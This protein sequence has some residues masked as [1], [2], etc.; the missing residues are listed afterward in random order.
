MLNIQ[1][2]L[3]WSR[4]SVIMYS[5]LCAFHVVLKT[6]SSDN[7][8]LGGCHELQLIN[9]ELQMTLSQSQPEWKKRN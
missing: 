8:E 9:D 4:P 3:V 6:V 5:A 7:L 2:L 1:E